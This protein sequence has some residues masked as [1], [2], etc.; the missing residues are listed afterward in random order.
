MSQS[1]KNLKIACYGLVDNNTGSCARA[2]FLVLEE[3]LRQNVQ[4]DFF[5]WRGYNR[6]SELSCYPNFRYID[7]PHVS[8]AGSNLPLPTKLRNALDPLFGILFNDASSFDAIRMTIAEH[9]KVQQYNGLLFLGLC[10]PFRIRG[11]KAISWVQGPP[12]AEWDF[13]RKNRSTI[14]KYCGLLLYAKLKFYY[15]L[16]HQ[17]IYTLKQ[18]DAVIC[19][20]QWSKSRILAMGLNSIQVYALPYP[21]RIDQFSAKKQPVSKQLGQEKVLLCLGRLDPRKRLDL[22]LTAFELVVKERPDVKLK[23]IGGF[24][25]VPGYSKMIDEYSH[26]DQLS[27]QASVPHSEIPNLIQNCDLLIQ[28]SEGENFGSSVSEALS[29]GL[30][31]IVGA[32]NGTRDYIGDSSF[33]FEG[34]T[35]ESLKNTILKALDVMETAAYSQTQSA[36]RAAEENFDVVTVVNHLQDIFETVFGSDHSSLGNRSLASQYATKA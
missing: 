23:V 31:V 17:S 30:P 26:L 11:L 15:L 18:T 25:Y 33:V 7:L 24:N 22:L 19:G 29:C 10:T 14:I 36:R 5:G 1:M 13:I 20:S 8:P 32:T 21:V 35:P 9:H 27:Y 28:P 12:R 6:A 4:I 2:Y 34:Y 3:L 16:K